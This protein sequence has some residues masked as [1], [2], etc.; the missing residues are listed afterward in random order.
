MNRSTAARLALAVLLSTGWGCGAS[1]KTISDTGYVGTWSRGADDRARSTLAIVRQGDQ[2][3]V[4]WNLE[5]PDGK[6]KVTCTWDGPCEEYRDGENVASYTFSTSTDPKTGHLIVECN[7]KNHVKD[8]K[9]LHYVDEFILK[10]K[11]L[12]LQVK[13]LAQDDGTFEESTRPRRR[14]EKIADA[15]ED[16]PRSLAK[17]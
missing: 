17:N 3:R 12:V 14:F 13:A 11:G 16:P 5:T 9:D 4:R 1:K 10:G 15:V 2:Y 8:G 7:G 6:W